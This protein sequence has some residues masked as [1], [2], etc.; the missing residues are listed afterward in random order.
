MS[1]RN[2]IL[3]IIIL[4]VIITGAFWYFYFYQSVNQNVNDTENTNFFANFL[5]FGKSENTTP[6]DKTPPTDI[7]RYESITEEENNL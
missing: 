6:G 7:S 4:V 2:L 1:K 5:P 3:L